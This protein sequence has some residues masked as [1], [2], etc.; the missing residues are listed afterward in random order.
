MPVS[1][2]EDSICLSET[3]FMANRHVLFCSFFQLLDTDKPV[4]LLFYLRNVFFIYLL[5]YSERFCHTVF[6]QY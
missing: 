6:M 3:P 5:I 4:R 2:G 1:I